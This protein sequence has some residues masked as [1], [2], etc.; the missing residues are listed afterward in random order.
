MHHPHLRLHPA[1]QT[2]SSS[3]FLPTRPGPPLHPLLL[4]VIH[5]PTPGVHASWEQE[6]YLEIVEHGLFDGADIMRS[7]L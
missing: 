2:H 3:Y 5:C 1:T 7:R 6:E 4:G